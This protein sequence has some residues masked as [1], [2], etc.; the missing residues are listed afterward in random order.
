MSNKNGYNKEGE[1]DYMQKGWNNNVRNCN[2]PIDRSIMVSDNQYEYEWDLIAAGVL[3][4]KLGLNEN[5]YCFH[6]CGKWWW[7][8]F[9][10]IEDAIAFKLLWVR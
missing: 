10:N 4:G 6:A 9:D 7:I 3:I 8:Q 2:I 5:K 1:T